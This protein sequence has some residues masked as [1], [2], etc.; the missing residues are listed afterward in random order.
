MT[1]LLTTWIMWAIIATTNPN[2]SAFVIVDE[3]DNKA[4][5]VLIAKEVATQTTKAFEQ[6]NVPGIDSITV[7]CIPVVTRILENA[8]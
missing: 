1:T 8:H 3:F 4:E 7:V 5:C 6:K 2:V